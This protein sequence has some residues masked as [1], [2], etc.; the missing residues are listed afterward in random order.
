MEPK[1]VQISVSPPKENSV[2][3][4]IFALDEQGQIWK[5]RVTSSSNELAEP[6]QQLVEP[7]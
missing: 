6:W 5:G 1:F 3:F 2:Y 7:E 4:Q